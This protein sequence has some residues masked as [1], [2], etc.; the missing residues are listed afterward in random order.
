MSKEPNLDL[1]SI[2]N[3]YKSIKNLKKYLLGNENIKRIAIQ[4]SKSSLSHAPIISSY[5]NL[6]ERFIFHLGETSYGDCCVDESTASHLRPDIIIRVGESCFIK[7]K[8]VKVF[9]LLESKE[10]SNSII[11]GIILNINQMISENSH[12]NRFFLMIKQDF[13]EYIET[14]S[15]G[16]IVNNEKKAYFPVDVN[17]ELTQ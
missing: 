1:E 13:R 4:Y 11:D 2:E 16:L 8:T 7:P 3:K 10:V 9:F 5:L 12:V 6:S 17:E 14:I 15:Q